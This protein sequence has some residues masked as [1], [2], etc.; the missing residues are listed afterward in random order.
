MILTVVTISLN[1]PSLEFEK[2]ILSLFSQSNTGINFCV[3][4]SRI[5]QESLAALRERLDNSFHSFTIIGNQ[6]SCLYNAMNIA[7]DA[8]GSTPVLFLNAGDVFYSSDSVALIYRNFQTNYVNAFSVANIFRESSAY[9]RFSNPKFYTKS[10][11][12][13][14]RNFFP[15]SPLR[16]RLPPHQGIV[17]IYESQDNVPLRFSENSE[18]SADSEL[19]QDLLGKGVVYHNDIICLFEFGGVSSRPSYNRIK[20]FLKRG[21]YLKAVLEPFLIIAFWLCPKNYFSLINFFAGNSP[22]EFSVFE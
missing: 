12:F 20:S 10:L 16:N 7:L 9:C 8:S 2:T 11:A 14:L 21:L 4:I 18:Y 15:A 19:I 5:S 1:Y 3:V 6:D 13:M 22:C 17:A